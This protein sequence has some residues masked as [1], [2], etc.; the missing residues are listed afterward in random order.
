VTSIELTQENEQFVEE[1]L[2]QGQYR[3]PD[4]LLN[5]ALSQLREYRELMRHIEEGNQQLR[6]GRYIEVDE[7]GLRAFFDDVK[8]RGRARAEERKNAT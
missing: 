4:E 2:A 6:D 3:S 7:T 1:A 5:E 8:A